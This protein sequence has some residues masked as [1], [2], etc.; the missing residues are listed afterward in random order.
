MV[1][2]GARMSELYVSV[3]GGQVPG[4]EWGAAAAA[5]GQ[6]GGAAAGDAAG[7]PRG[8]E[9]AEQHPGGGARPALRGRPRPGPQP[10]PPH[11]P[12]GALTRCFT[13]YRSAPLTNLP[14]VDCVIS[15]ENDHPDEVMKPPASQAELA[16]LSSGGD[17]CFDFP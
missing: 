8:A 5:A 11:R 6:P 12:G 13:R 9:H 14:Y 2:P 15:H 7:R 10:H 16:W 4:P 1:T 3:A 17:R